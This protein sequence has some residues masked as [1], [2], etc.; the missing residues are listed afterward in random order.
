MFVATPVQAWHHHALVQQKK[1]VANIA[2]QTV[3]ASAE[4]CAVCQHT[5]AVYMDA[6]VGYPAVILSSC[7][8]LWVNYLPIF[9]SVF[10]PICT[11][12]GPPV[13]ACIC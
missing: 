11:N 13:I 12:K 4:P 10:L 6:A 7:T 3:A 9:T 8:F 5:Y 1:P 2:T